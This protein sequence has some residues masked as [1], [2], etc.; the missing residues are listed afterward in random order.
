MQARRQHKWQNYGLRSRIFFAVA[1]AVRTRFANIAI[2]QVLV[3]RGS[4]FV[5]NVDS[6]S[7]MAVSRGCLCPDR[8]PIFLK[9]K[10]S[11]QVRVE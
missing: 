3:K 10:G 4:N 8:W 11:C 9:L 2:S 7:K 6:V 5:Y 1:R